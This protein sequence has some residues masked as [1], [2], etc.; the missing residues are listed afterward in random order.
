MQINN[1]KEHWKKLNTG[2]DKSWSTCAT[3]MMSQREM[4]FINIYLHKIK[5]K[6]ILDIGIGT[7]RVLENLVVNSPNNS[8]IYGVDYIDKMV[9]YCKN[10]FISNRKIKELTVCDISEERLSF[11]GRFDFITAVRVLQYSRN[12]QDILRKIYS[13]LGEGGIFI[14]SMPNYDSINRFVPSYVQNDKITTGKLRKILKEIGFQTLEVNSVTRIPDFFYQNPFANIVFYS[15]FL[16]KIEKFLELIFGKV[17][18]GR[19]LFVAV[20]KN[21][22]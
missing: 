9:S 6:K 19:I 16:I 18:L 13:K 12:W 3:R 15:K 21:K 4:N 1:D 10:K 7:G 22:H 8:D 11:E 17:L 2:Y 20:E 14:F 5:P